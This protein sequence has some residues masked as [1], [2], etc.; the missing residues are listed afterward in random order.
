MLTC[1]EANGQAWN[2]KSAIGDGGRNN[3]HDEDKNHCQGEFGS[4]CPQC[5]NNCQE[6]TDDVV[7]FTLRFL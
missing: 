2:E 5:V 1:R 3:S 6:V 4:G 7:L